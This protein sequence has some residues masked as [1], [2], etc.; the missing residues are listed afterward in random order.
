MPEYRVEEF[1]ARGDGT[2]KCTKAIQEAIELC[3]K[4]GGRKSLSDKNY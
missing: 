2:M 1:G 3:Y 4:E